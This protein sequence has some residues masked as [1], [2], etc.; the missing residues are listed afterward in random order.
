MCAILCVWFS[1]FNRTVA[2]QME[3]E[4]KLSSTPNHCSQIA[5]ILTT[6]LKSL[7]YIIDL[8]PVLLL[9]SMKVL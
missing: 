6:N 9:T 2:D 1:I 7:Q 8:V 4:H 3:A 5:V